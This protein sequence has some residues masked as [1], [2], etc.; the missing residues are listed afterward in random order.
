[1]PSQRVLAIDLEE[2]PDRGAVILPEGTGH[3]PGLRGSINPIRDP[4]DR[5]YVY[6][7]NIAIDQ[8]K[9]QPVYFR[10]GEALHLTDAD[11][12]SKLVR[13]VDIAGRSALLE[14]QPGPRDAH[15]TPA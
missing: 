14:Y 12:R 8:G 11:G 4:L 13:I 6:A 7:S 15:V 5:T 9:A 3:I 2:L 10:L 1:M